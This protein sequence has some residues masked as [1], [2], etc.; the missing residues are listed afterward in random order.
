MTMDA[1]GNVTQESYGN[2]INTSRAFDPQ[3][4]QLTDIDTKLGTV[5]I[6]D[7][8]YRWQSNGVLESRSR[9][10]G[11]VPVTETFSYDGLNRLE[12]AVSALA[13][14][15]LGRYSFRGSTFLAIFFLS[16]LLLPFRLAIM[17]LF[18][19]LQDLGLVD[20]RLGL[21]L[22]KDYQESDAGQAG[23]IIEQLPEPGIE[24]TVGTK[25]EQP[26]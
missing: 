1:Y 16:G 23:R 8:V 15:I 14:Y 11:G 3:T 2:G 26:R 9:D 22:E 19:L 13:A 18:L 5:E 21:I 17:P 4:G 24:V 10:S 6:L 25:G 7:N 20:T 12:T